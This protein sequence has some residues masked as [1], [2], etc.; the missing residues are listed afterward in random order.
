[1]TQEEYIAKLE[2]RI[3]YL[4]KQRAKRR[5]KYAEEKSKKHVEARDKIIALDSLW[6]KKYNVLL[7]EYNDFFFSV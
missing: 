1:M 2:Q 7:K 5:K 3:D 6:Q 4:E